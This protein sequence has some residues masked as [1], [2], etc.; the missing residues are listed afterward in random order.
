MLLLSAMDPSCHIPGETCLMDVLVLP[1]QLAALLVSG[2]VSRWLFLLVGCGAE[3]PCPTAGRS[4]PGARHLLH[5]PS[6]CLLLV[7][8]LHKRGL[9]PLVCLYRIFWGDSL[10]AVGVLGWFSMDE[11][12]S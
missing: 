3:S 2:D 4:Q 12:S 5:P 7:P 10:T 6:L 11:L 9:P 1:Q 8:C